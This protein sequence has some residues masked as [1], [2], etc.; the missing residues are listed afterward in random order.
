MD[1]QDNPGEGIPI[2]Y[3]KIIQQDGYVTGVAVVES[4]GGAG[5]FEIRVSGQLESIEAYAQQARITRLDL[6]VL[7]DEEKQVEANRQRVLA[8][9]RQEW[10]EQL[11]QLKTKVEAADLTELN[12]LDSL[13]KQLKP[14]GKEAGRMNS[15]EDL[16]Q[17]RLIEIIPLD[18]QDPDQ[19]H[20][21]SIAIHPTVPQGRRDIYK[22]VV[23]GTVSASASITVSAGDADLA[24]YRSGKIFDASLSSG[25]S[26]A[27]FGQGGVGQWKLHVIGFTNATY[28]VFGDWVLRKNNT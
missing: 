24:L 7:D 17:D 5:R 28:Q 22:P 10:L 26:D 18:D 4:P 3:E 1:F 20:Q 2:H 15:E 9:N 23:T 14:E 11:N 19:P 12:D 21:L 27:V 25:N 16:S 8:A 13:V 6:N